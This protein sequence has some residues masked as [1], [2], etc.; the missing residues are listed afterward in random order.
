MT[1]PNALELMMPDFTEERKS[2][3]SALA[4]RLT[5]RILWEIVVST[6]PPA[7]TIRQ[8]IRRQQ[9]F[10]KL[11]ADYRAKL[12]ERLTELLN[13]L[14]EDGIDSLPEDIALLVKEVVKAYLERKV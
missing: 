7:T 6:S 10:D 1:Y 12:F 14:D 13:M 2:E 8:R 11:L 9:E 3:L 5:R 4:Y